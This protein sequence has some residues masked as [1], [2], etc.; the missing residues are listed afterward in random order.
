M[1]D[2]PICSGPSPR[3]STT[4]ELVTS[5]Q[6]FILYMGRDGS[7]ARSLLKMCRC[8]TV[9]LTVVSDSQ[10]ARC[11][12]FIMSKGVVPGV[13]VK[14]DRACSILQHWQREPFVCHDELQGCRLTLCQFMYMYMGHQ[15]TGEVSEFSVIFPEALVIVLAGSFGRTGF[16]RIM[17]LRSRYLSDHTSWQIFQFSCSNHVCIWNNNMNNPI[18]E[19]V[20]CHS[21]KTFGARV[22]FEKGI[23]LRASNYPIPFKEPSLD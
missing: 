10:F 14:V 23:P 8:R 7:L 9:G 21:V 2:I 11:F 22:H 19:R 12:S 5:S 4:S 17:W 15:C 3:P 13:H 1:S 6:D 18:Y 20:F 16:C